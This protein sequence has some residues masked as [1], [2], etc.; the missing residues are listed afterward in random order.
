MD[1]NTAILMLIYTLFLSSLIFQVHI[2]TQNKRKTR[3]VYIYACSKN[4]HIF[5]KAFRN[6]FNKA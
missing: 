3:G 6:I 4:I 1:K 5:P 2:N